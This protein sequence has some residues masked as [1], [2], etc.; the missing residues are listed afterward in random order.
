MFGRKVFALSLILILCLGTGT[1]L[2]LDENPPSEH[3]L[4]MT[5]RANDL[6]VRLSEQ[7]QRVGDH[8][9]ANYNNGHI[10]Y[11]VADN[12]LQVLCITLRHTTDAVLAP[13]KAQCERENVSWSCVYT[14]V[15]IGWRTVLVDPI[16]VP[17]NSD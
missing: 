6:V 13:V 10:S 7:A 14:P 11:E 4:Q 16:I 12:T 2:A 17:G 8:I 15:E 1:A 5:A 3:L 9:V